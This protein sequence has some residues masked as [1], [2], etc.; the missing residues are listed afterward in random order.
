MVLFGDSDSCHFLG[1]ENLEMPIYGNGNLFIDL[2]VKNPL[3]FYFL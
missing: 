2:Q 1:V 3:H